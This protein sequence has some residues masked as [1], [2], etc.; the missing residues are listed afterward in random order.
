MKNKFL[1]FINSRRSIRD[2][3]SEHIS[4]KDIEKILESGMQ[5]PSAGNQ[6]PWEFVVINKHELLTEIPR[7]HPYSKMLKTAPAAILVCGNPAKCQHKDFWV[8]D[9]SAATQNMLLAIHS[10][11]LGGVWLGV[12]PDSGR[13]EGLRELLGIP[14]NIIPFS[15]IAFGHFEGSVSVQDRFDPEKIHI[16]IW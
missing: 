8:Q 7:I 4:K 9:C 13:M 3:T 16:N 2:F 10:L 1:D 15:L 14:D 12:Y 5:A 11:N 6:Q